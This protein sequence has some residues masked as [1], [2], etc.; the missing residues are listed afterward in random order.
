MRIQSWM[1]WFYDNFGQAPKRKVFVSGENM[2]HSQICSNR[3][4]LR[5]GHPPK[6]G[7]QHGG[8]PAFKK[9]VARLSR[10]TCNQP[11]KR[12]HVERLPPRTGS[13]EPGHRYE[14]DRGD[15]E[16]DRRD[17]GRSQRPS[18]RRHRRVLHGRVPLDGQHWVWHQEQS[19]GV[20]GQLAETLSGI[21]CLKHAL[22]KL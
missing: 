7:W 8:R 12:H 4:H 19:E 5:W 13:F 22:C 20:S 17:G 21:T 9:G 3:V 18:D 16:S 6:T 15:P 10:F 11:S 1:I 14:Q 2:R